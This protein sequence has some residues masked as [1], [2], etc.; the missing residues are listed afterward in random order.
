M[1][2]YIERV[3]ED[4]KKRNAGEPEYLRT[5]EEVYSSLES[6]VNRHPEY[7]RPGFDKNQTA[8]KMRVNES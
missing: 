5:V 2:A 4:I 6:V 7:A 8:E 1:N 3:L